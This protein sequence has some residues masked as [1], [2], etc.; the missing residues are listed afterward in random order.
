M[1]AVGADVLPTLEQLRTA[2]NRRR[3][4]DRSWPWRILERLLGLEMKMRQYETGRSFCDEVVAE[5]GPAALTIAWSSAEM[6]PSTHE[7]EHPHEWL[8]RTQPT[9]APA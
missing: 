1:D 6:L 3:R 4:T 8:A 5:A 2:M 9:A 7:L